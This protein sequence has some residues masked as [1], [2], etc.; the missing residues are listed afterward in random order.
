MTRQQWDTIERS[1][2][3]LSADE[4]REV[5]GRILESVREADP[6]D[7][8]AA[9]QREALGRLCRTVDALPPAATTDGFSNRDHDLLLYAR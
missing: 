7:A 3:G 4:R 5:A 6:S 8:R 2:A 1:L 9:R